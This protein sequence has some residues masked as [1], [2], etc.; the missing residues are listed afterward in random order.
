MSLTITSLSGS[1][2]FREN[3]IRNIKVYVLPRSLKNVFKTKI[4]ASVNNNYTIEEIEKGVIP[5]I[6]VSYNNITLHAS[7]DY[8]V[9]Y[10]NNRKAGHATATVIGLNGY[11]GRIK[12]KYNIVLSEK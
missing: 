6:T 3:S 9:I 11:S 10:N 8:D 7:S 4:T 2:N 1:L 5:Q 12:I